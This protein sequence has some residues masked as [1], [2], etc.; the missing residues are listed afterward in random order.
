[1]YGLSIRDSAGNEYIKASNGSLFLNKSNG[2]P[3]FTAYDGA[4]DINGSLYSD[5]INTGGLGN[6]LIGQNLRTTDSPTFA[7]MR[8]SRYRNLT[9]SANYNMPAMSLGES[10]VYRLVGN[11]TTARTIYLP[12]GGTYCYIWFQLS[13]T[14]SYYLLYQEEAY[15]QPLAVL[16]RNIIVWRLT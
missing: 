10:C 14:E 6:F 5:T 16:S 2:L 11:N 7:N 8:P 3:F 15:L 1:M 4:V 9:L 13:P 12:S